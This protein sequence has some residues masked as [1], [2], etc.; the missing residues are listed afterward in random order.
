VKLAAANAGN[1]T[2]TIAKDVLMHALNVQ[3]N[4]GKRHHKKRKDRQTM[5]VLFI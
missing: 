4:A 5:L 1:M 2:M 3:K